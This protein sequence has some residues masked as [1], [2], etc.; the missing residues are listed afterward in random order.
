MALTPSDLYLPFHTYVSDVPTYLGDMTLWAP[1]QHVIDTIGLAVVVMSIWAVAFWLGRRSN[2]SRQRTRQMR[3]DRE[4]EVKS[5]I[6]DAV[7]EAIED[8]VFNGKLKRDEAGFWYNRLG[9]VL[10]IPDVLQK[11]TQALKEKLKEK[12]KGKTKTNIVPLR[13][14]FLVR[15]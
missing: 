15:N 11:N 8:L 12:H 5:M 2:P 10:T 6:G 13:K 1:S 14:K 9:N 4:K 7:T 3:W